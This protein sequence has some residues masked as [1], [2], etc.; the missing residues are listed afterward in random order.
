MDFRLSAEQELLRDSARRYFAAE[1]PVEQRRQCGLRD[2]E[3]W[4]R[5]ADLGWLAM[6]V[7]EDAGGLGASLEDIAILC[8]E[9]GRGLSQ[10]PFIGGAILPSRVLDLCGA[11]PARE[12]L[13]QALAR[14]SVRLAL[15]V[16]EPDRRYEL[17]PGTC[18]TASPDGALRLTGGKCLVTGGAQATRVIV[19]ARIDERS[20]PALFLVDA[21]RAGVHRRIYEMIDGV[22]AADFRFDNVIVSRAE[23]LAGPDTAPAVL[24]DGF[25]AATLCLCAE[26]LGCMDQAIEMTAGYLK[27]RKQFGRP[28][29]EF[30]VLQHAVAEMS[31]DANS[32]RSMVYRALAAWRGSRIER[33]Q[34][35]SGC[36]IKVMQAAKSVTGSAVH[37]HGGIGMTCEYP[38]GHF[39]RRV[40]VSER[41]FG[42]REYQLARYLES[43]SSGSMNAAAYEHR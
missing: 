12:T 36:A 26:T 29:A 2:A 6:P 23:M 5:F 1:E 39:L 38:V 37:L 20:E 14:N 21:N 25:D 9:M 8:E 7:P 41:I 30:Q 40:V 3:N 32:A 31:I 42:D 11:W 27:L 28:L 35:I 43:S 17:R 24:E 34:A 19:S 13:L 33:R 10:A 4:A 15:A 16:Y 18:A 22:Q